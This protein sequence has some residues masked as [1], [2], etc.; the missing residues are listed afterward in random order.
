MGCTREHGREA[1]PGALTEGLEV[2]QLK[3]YAA[4]QSQCRWSRGRPAG[5]RSGPVGCSR[6]WLLPVGP[7]AGV[8]HSRGPPEPAL[9]D[10]AHDVREAA[11][12]V[13]TCQPCWSGRFGLLVGTIQLV[14]LLA[15]IRVQGG[16]HLPRHRAGQTRRDQPQAGII[17]STDTSTETEPAPAH[18]RPH[19]APASARQRAR[20]LGCHRA[21]TRSSIVCSWRALGRLPPRPCASPTAARSTGTHPGERP[22]AGSSPAPNAIGPSVGQLWSRALAECREAAPAPRLSLTCLRGRF[23]SDRPFQGWVG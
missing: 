2:E 7:R 19:R 4:A 15:G 6:L 20:T 12:P 3:V 17:R 23:A 11:R 14:L 9:V 1:F 16:D 5:P 8:V 10:K 13:N 22:P 18:G 21:R